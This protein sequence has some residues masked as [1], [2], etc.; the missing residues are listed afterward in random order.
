MGLEMLSTFFSI[1]FSGF[2]ISLSLILAIGPQNSF[3]IRQG[4]LNQH[5]LAVVLFCG[6]SD[7]LLICL[8]VLGLGTIMAP[9]FT[10]FSDWMFGLSALW[11]GLYALGRVRAAY[12]ADYPAQADSEN[13]NMESLRGIFALL[14]VLTFANPH[15]YLDTVILLGA[16][17]LGYPGAEKLVFAGGA[18]LASLCFFATI[19]FGAKRLSPLMTSNR[20]WQIL[21]IFTA[22][23]MAIFASILLAQTSWLTGA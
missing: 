19:G 6:I 17:S 10:Q 5:V 12:R 16:I 8:G 3:V 13:Q 1:F 11:L 22:L 15:V 7:A 14:A 4:L 18:S 23:I 9:V 2:F 21:D 20:A